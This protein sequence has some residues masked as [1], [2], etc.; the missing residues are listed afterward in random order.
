M[1]SASAGNDRSVVELSMT[2]E[3]LMGKNILATAVITA[4]MA[5]SG[6]ALAQTT[7]QGGVNQPPSKQSAP[8]NAPEASGHDAQTGKPATGE[9]PQERRDTTGSAEKGDASKTAK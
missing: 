4:A 6:L 3:E 5:V 2:R 8:A 9:T 1:M 7:N